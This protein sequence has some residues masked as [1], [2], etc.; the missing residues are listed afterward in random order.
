MNMANN[1]L[2]YAG[3]WFGLAIVLVIISGLWHIRFWKNRA[4]QN[5]AR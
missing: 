4:S 2:Q 3:T 1:H 5:G